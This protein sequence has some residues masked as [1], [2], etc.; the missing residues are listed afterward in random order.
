MELLA[1]IYFTVMECKH[2]HLDLI[3]QMHST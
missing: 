3:L 1:Q 2:Y